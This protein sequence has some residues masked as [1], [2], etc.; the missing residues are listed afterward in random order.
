MKSKKII[1]LLK[2]KLKKS[3]GIENEIEKTSF[4]GIVEIV[5]L[6]NYFFVNKAERCKILE[7]KAEI[8]GSKILENKIEKN[9]V[10]VQNDLNTSHVSEVSDGATKINSVTN[11]EATVAVEKVLD[12]HSSHDIICSELKN[13]LLHGTQKINKLKKSLKKKWLK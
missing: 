13:I 8:V 10:E 11:S 1:L 2:I 12:V 3:I 4:H 6:N 7:N 5:A 9:Q